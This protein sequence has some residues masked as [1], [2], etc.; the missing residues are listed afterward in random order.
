MQRAR[1]MSE[2]WIDGFLALARIGGRLRP[3]TAAR[4]VEVYP[5]P[6]EALG[7]GP[8]PLGR[9]GELGAGEV[10]ALGSFDAWDEMRA[11]RE[12]CADLGIRLIPLGPAP[13]PRLLT[14][15]FDPPPVLYLCGT[16]SPADVAAVGL[17]G[18]R[19]ASRYGLAAAR[20]IGQGLARQGVTVVSGLAL[21]VDAEAHRGALEGRGRTLAVLGCGVDRIYPRS[22]RRLRERI[23][24]SG[25]VLSELPLGTPPLPHHF[26]PRNRIV[27]GLSLGVV[28]AEA[29][30]ASGSLITA[31]S[32]SEQGRT[33]FALPG[34][35]DARG[36]EGPLDLL[37]R[38]AIAIGSA[39][40]VVEDLR[41]ILDRLGHR[42]PTST[43]EDGAP[44]AGGRVLRELGPTPRSLDELLERTGLDRGTL[45]TLLL[46]LELEGRVRR[47]ADGA[48]VAREL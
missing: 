45:A 48:Y 26:P 3:G 32:A 28:V 47:S 11:E 19:H 6:R 24:A 7:R 10:D 15:I 20:A 46:D 29:A 18:S 42:A 25:A 44:A 41:P 16:L 9:L 38:G 1:P 39:D 23:E 43:A 27:S 36:T 40:H 30:R 34:P 22:N 14:R 4:L 12:R 31:R 33:V 21:G 8:G 2:P 5:D 13:Y 37:R 17:V 35:V